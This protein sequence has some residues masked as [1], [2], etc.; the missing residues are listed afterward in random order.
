DEALPWVRRSAER[1]P[2]NVGNVGGSRGNVYDAIGETAQAEATLRRG[3][4]LGPKVGLTHVAMMSFCLR[5]QRTSE[6]LQ[7]ARNALNLVPDD[8]YVIRMAGITELSAGH[9]TRA[10]ELLERVLPSLQGR[11]SRLVQEGVETYLAWLDT[12]AGSRARAKQR[13]E[14]ARIADRRELDNGNEGWSVPFDLACV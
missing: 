14:A 12:K 1:D 2:S 11:R 8:P 7:V 13:L 5:H 10:R 6:A 3:L 9:E 4:E